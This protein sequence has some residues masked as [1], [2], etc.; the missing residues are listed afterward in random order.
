MPS[1]KGKYIVLYIYTAKEEKS[2]ANDF[3]IYLK[4]TRKEESPYRFP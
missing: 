3:S 4:K 2:Q 1:S